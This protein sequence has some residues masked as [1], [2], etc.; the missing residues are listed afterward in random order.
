MTK[1]SEGINPNDH[2]IVQEY[3]DHPLLIDDLKFDFRIYV[4]IK[5][6][7]PLKIFMYPE[8]LARLATVKY[9]PPHKNNFDNLMM[10]LTNY[11]INKKSENFI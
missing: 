1:R 6:I 4:L 11:A 5:N 3:I 8:G 2:M 9:R 10:H 7:Q